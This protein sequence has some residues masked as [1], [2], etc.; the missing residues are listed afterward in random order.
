MQAFPEVPHL[1]L[2]ITCRASLPRVVYTGPDR[3]TNG[4]ALL[5]TG[6]WPRCLDHWMSNCPPGGAD[7]HDTP[8]SVTYIL[9]FSCISHRVSAH[10]HTGALHSATTCNELQVSC[11]LFFFKG[12]TN[13]WVQTQ[14]QL[15]CKQPSKLLHVVH[16]CSY[17]KITNEYHNNLLSS[18]SKILF[19]HLDNINIIMGCY[20]LGP[21]SL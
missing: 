12:T 11:R 15:C 18:F 8:K 4:S 3:L 5:D 14:M 16:L 17:A 7:P 2:P 20:F 9:F 6:P 13:D 10:A 21:L 19:R 1:A